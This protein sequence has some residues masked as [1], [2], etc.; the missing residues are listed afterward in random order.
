MSTTFTAVTFHE[1]FKVT[2]L[3]ANFHLDFGV[4]WTWIFKE[5]RDPFPFDGKADLMLET[6]FNAIDDDNSGG[7]DEA[8]LT[9]FFKTIGRSSVSRRAIPNLTRLSDTD[10]NGLI[11]WE[12]FK[13]IW[14]KVGC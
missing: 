8:E 10:G 6:A 2:A 3:D 12:E 7:L 5:L 14:E 11:D 4:E 1:L 9:Q 13:A